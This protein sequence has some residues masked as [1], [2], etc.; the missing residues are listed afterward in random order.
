MLPGIG[1]SLGQATVAGKPGHGAPIR[2]WGAVVGLAWPCLGLA[3]AGCTPVPDLPAERMALRRVDSL[4]AVET[5]A[6]GANGWAEFFEVSGVMLPRHGRIDGRE[7]IRAFMEPVFGPDEPRLQWRATDVHVGAGGDLGY[8]MGRWQ[9]IG[10]TVASADTVLRE[11]HY[12]TIW[13]K[14]TDGTWHVAVDI[15]NTDDADK[16]AEAGP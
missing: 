16:M 13:R 14:G 3:V 4:F 1:E 11:G 6:R 2:L 12:L 8:T 7:A 10:T 15:G 5:G 9:S